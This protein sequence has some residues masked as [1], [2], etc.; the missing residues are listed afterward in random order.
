VGH[1][2][3]NSGVSGRGV[4]NPTL[5]ALPTVP[6]QEA[7]HSGAARGGVDVALGALSTAV[8]LRPRAGHSG[9]GLYNAP[10]RAVPFTI[11]FLGAAFTLRL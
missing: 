10:G 2:L 8:L 11:L 7:N 6:L 3:D 1:V 4:D 5:D 9:S